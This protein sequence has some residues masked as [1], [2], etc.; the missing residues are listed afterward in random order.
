MMRRRPFIMLVVSV[1]RPGLFGIRLASRFRG[2]C[3]EGL[4]M[5]SGRSS[6]EGG[7]LCHIWCSQ[8]VCN[9]T[10]WFSMAHSNITKSEQSNLNK[11]KQPE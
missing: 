5:L 3:V 2:G 6:S 1:R 9:G 7:S 11:L 4:V 8:A 10:L